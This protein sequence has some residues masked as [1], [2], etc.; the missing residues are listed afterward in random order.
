MPCGTPHMFSWLHK[1]I[2]VANGDVEL[3]ES[4]DVALPD[5]VLPDVAF[6]V[7]HPH[8][9]FLDEARAYT[10]MTAWM[11]KPPP[12]MGSVPAHH[13]SGNSG[14]GNLISAWMFQM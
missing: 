14:I 6:L 7:G 8:V 1:S 2:P 13:A 10:G 3:L 5:V 11:K 9:S 12:G 4:P